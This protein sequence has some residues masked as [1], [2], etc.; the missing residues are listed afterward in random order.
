MIKQPEVYIQEEKDKSDMFLFMK[1]FTPD[2]YDKYV[3]IQHDQN[4]NN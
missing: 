2:L 4:T 3:K 1:I